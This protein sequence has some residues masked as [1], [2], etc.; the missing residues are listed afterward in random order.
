MN[1]VSDSHPFSI[2]LSS[3]DSN[4]DKKLNESELNGIPAATVVVKTNPNVDLFVKSYVMAAGYPTNDPEMEARRLLFI[5]RNKALLAKTDKLDEAQVKRCLQLLNDREKRDIASYNE[6]DESEVGI[7]DSDKTLSDYI[8]RFVATYNYEKRPGEKYFKDSEGNKRFDSKGNPLYID[9]P[10]GSKITGHGIKLSECDDLAIVDIDLKPNPDQPFSNDEKEA[11]RSKLL[12]M[13]DPSDIVDQSCSGGMHVYCKWDDSIPNSESQN[14]F[15]D[16]CTTWDSRIHIDLFLP[17]AKHSSTFVVVPPFANGL[18]PVKCEALNHDNEIGEYK[19]IRNNGE[20]PVRR[21]L[22]DVLES[23]QCSYTPKKSA[24]IESKAIV[25]AESETVKPN[26]NS[27]RRDSDEIEWDDV[28]LENEVVQ[29]LV[30]GI[31]GFVVHNYT[32]TGDNADEEVTLLV[33][34]KALN[35]IKDV[36]LREI[37]YA[38]AFKLCT[39]RAKNR[40]NDEKSR[41][42]D[43]KSSITMLIKIV[44]RFNSS[45]YKRYVLPKIGGIHVKE[46][47]MNDDFRLNDFK[48]N[49]REGRYKT[50]SFAANELSRIYRYHTEGDHY[51]IEKGYDAMNNMISF[52]FVKYKTVV[53]KLKLIHLFDKEITK[54]NGKKRTVSYSAWDAFLKYDTYFHF[55]GVRFNVRRK[56]VITYFHGYKYKVL[57]QYDESVISDYLKLIHDVIADSREQ[58]Y[59]YILNWMSFVVQNPGKRTMVTFVIKGKQGAGKN[60]FSDIFAEL[61]SGYSEPN[62]TKI[63]ELT[64]KYNDVIENCMFMVLNEI[65]SARGCYVQDMDALKSIITDP[66]M[67]VRGPYEPYRRADNVS[68]L[69]IMSNHAKPISV[70]ADDRRFVVLNVNGMYSNAK[71]I[72]DLHYVDVDFYNHLLTYLTKRDIKDFA[73]FRDSP[74][75]YE[76]LDI[77]TASRQPYEKFIVENYDALTR[78]ITLGE[79]KRLYHNSIV[80]SPNQRLEPK[81]FDNIQAQLKDKCI[82]GGR[83]QIRRIDGSRP[84]VYMLKEEWLSTYKPEALDDSEQECD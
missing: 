1:S 53:E 67:R 79:L 37:A 80:F 38:K 7:N 64:G 20:S 33:L 41:L 45:Y 11:L 43:D 54:E 62:V 13:L 16:S 42:Y 24:V 6:S 36:K 46:F 69:I 61:L 68:N 31:D 84:H 22:S 56:D 9:A 58:I 77:I 17:T 74:I 44:K 19:W 65:K 4:S 81:H 51:F 14:R 83:K 75:T 59:E 47:D 26:L 25:S 60:T 78:G 49:A 30:D 50:L 34:F 48:T 10:Y 15:T 35:C 23:I 82:Q 8:P 57:E 72:A 3:S 40:F 70:P 2:S 28:E 12:G 5:D 52:K 66:T 29:L 55:N 18:C 39:E 73:P 32:N 27:K 63:D 21:T 71:Y 76:K